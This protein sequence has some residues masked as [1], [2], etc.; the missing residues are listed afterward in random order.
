MFV[1]TL[2]FSLVKAIFG[3]S[4]AKTGTAAVAA[5]GPSVFAA[6]HGTAVAATTVPTPSC[7][8]YVTCLISKFTL[9]IWKYCTTTEILTESRERQADERW[10]ALYRKA[11]RFLDQETQLLPEKVDYDF[12]LPI[13]LLLCIRIIL[14][15]IWC[16]R[17]CT[18]I[19]IFAIQGYFY[20][21]FH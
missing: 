18:E 9:G 19:L 17:T 3:T 7:T 12:D 13:P 11:L 10:S 1:S 15:G 4:A 5:H 21:L 8:D 2:F 16:I 6:S 20:V 14:F